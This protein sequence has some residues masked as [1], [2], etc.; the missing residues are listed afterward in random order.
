M[1]AALIGRAAFHAAVERYP[2]ARLTLHQGAGVVLKLP[3]D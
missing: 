1:I 2:R 3:S